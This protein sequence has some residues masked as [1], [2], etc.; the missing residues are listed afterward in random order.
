MSRRVWGDL[1]RANPTRDGHPKW[2]ECIPAVGV[3]FLFCKNSGLES[4]SAYRS[5]EP[6]RSPDPFP[7]GFPRVFTGPCKWN[8][9]STSAG[10]DFVEQ[11]FRMANYELPMESLKKRLPCDTSRREV[12]VPSQLESCTRKLASWCV[13]PVHQAC[14]YR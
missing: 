4:P 10:R 11:L 2:T 1:G 9:G 13:G 7:S 14:P 12:R 5:S 8:E 3:C 6:R